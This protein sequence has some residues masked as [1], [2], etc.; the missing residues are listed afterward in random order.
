MKK[1]VWGLILILVAV[2]LTVTVRTFTVFKKQQL[3][4]GD[5]IELSQLNQ[6]QAITR[7]SEALRYK[8]ISFDDT[9]KIDLQAFS[10]FHQYLEKSYP[11]I[12]QHLNKT[13]INTHSVIYHMPGKDKTRLPALFL[14]HIDVVPI[15]K[16][17]EDQWTHPPFS[18]TVTDTSIFG[19]GTM[20]D[21]SS[22]MALMESVELMLASG[23]Q[24]A[25]DIYLAFGHDE[26]IGGFAGAA[27]IAQYFASQNIRFEF[28]LDEGGAITQGMMQGIKSPVA[29][30]GIAEKGY[31]NFNLTVDAQGGH[32]SQPPKHTAVG[33]L[34]KAIV[35]IEN[36]PLSPSLQFMQ[37][38]FDAIGSEA[39]ID[40]KA[41]MSNL[42]L[43][44]ALV[45]SSIMKKPKLAAS[46]HT[47]MAATMISGSD[48]SNVLPT[49]ATAVVNARL[50][51][52]STTEDI[53]TYLTKVINDNRVKITADVHSQPSPVSTVDSF[54]FNLIAQSIRDLDSEVLVAPYLVQGGTD[55]KYFY[56]VSDNVYRFLPMRV[57]A[58]SL[59]RLHGIDEQITQSD[60]ID[61]IKF[62]WR[63]ISKV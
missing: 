42:W 34:S 9:H 23:K 24:P 12:H 39:A 11:L 44:S 54:G 18:G 58:D 5:P 56:Q 14:A 62:Y 41:I 52:G 36:N 53:K 32:S 33:I 29:L 4:T 35:N 2:A 63:V 47:T 17:T 60:Y 16:I 48:K 61:T 25:R 1:L 57:N 20:D 13:V 19:R 49:R 22:L 7:L 30:I 55:S 38:T 15:D 27:K 40:V 37:M 28:V 3:T 21:K 59:K 26:E 8:T 45:K 43:T 10:D 50:F 6:Q 46:L 51:P 31:V